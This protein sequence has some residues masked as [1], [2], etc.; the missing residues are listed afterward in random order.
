M[1]DKDEQKVEADIYIME[2]FKPEL[3]EL[4]FHTNYSSETNGKK[5]VTHAE[6]TTNYDYLPDVRK[7]S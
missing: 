3:L 1:I 4:Q 7:S 2:N 6:R 5:Y